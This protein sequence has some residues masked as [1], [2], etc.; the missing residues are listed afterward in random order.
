M[1]VIHHSNLFR[2][3]F[4]RQ[5]FLPIFATVKTGPIVQGIERKFPKLQIRVRVAV[6]L[7]KPLVSGGFF[8]LYILICVIRKFVKC[9]K[10]VLFHHRCMAKQVSCLRTETFAT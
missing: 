2:K 9:T 4:A 6:G 5:K 3:G 10:P 7:Q 1:S 8:M